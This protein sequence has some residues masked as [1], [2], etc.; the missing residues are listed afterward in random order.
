MRVIFFDTETTGNAERDRLCQLAVREWRAKQP[1]LNA[2]FKPPHPIPFE[3]MAI[4]HITQKM[5]NDRP[6]F[7]EAPEYES[8]KS[9]FEDENSV[10][11]AHNAAFDLAMLARE[12]ITPR[13]HIC[14]Y[15]VARALDKEETLGVYQLQYL[16]YALG[17]EVDAVAHDAMGDCLV[18]EQLFERLLARVASEEGNEE[19]ALLYMIGLSRQPLLFTT[20]RFGKY[21]GKRLEDIAKSDRGYLE[22]LLAEKRKSPS[23][24]EDWIHT[25]EHYLG[26]R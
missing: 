1:I 13:A 22:W 16:R 14:T 18:L 25:L 15:K 9:L 4:H 19:K 24:E 20:L 12:H 3:A 6:A 11:V 21:K 26:N 2:L 5:V 7:L 8:I 17:I 10:V 23:G